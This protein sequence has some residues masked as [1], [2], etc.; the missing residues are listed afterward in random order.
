MRPTIKAIIDTNI[1]ISSTCGRK[2][3]AHAVER[4][5]LLVLSARTTQVRGGGLQILNVAPRLSFCHFTLH[6]HAPIPQL[7]G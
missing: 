1:L 5:A 2:S 7:Y 6:H 4:A 3:L